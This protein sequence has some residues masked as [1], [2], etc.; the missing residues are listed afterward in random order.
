VSN[1]NSDAKK[2]TNFQYPR[3]DKKHDWDLRLLTHIREREKKIGND[4][5]YRRIKRKAT[6]KDET[7]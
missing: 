3:T 4:R 2:T 7:K 5:K 6:W 1:Y